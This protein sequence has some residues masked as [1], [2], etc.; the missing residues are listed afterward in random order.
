MRNLHAEAVRIYLVWPFTGTSPDM[1]AATGCLGDGATGPLGEV[2]YQTDARD[3]VEGGCVQQLASVAGPRRR[4]D[5][6]GGTLFWIGTTQ[7]GRGSRRA[8]E[9]RA[10]TL[11]TKK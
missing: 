7:A 1:G 4:R 3:P 2:V 6:H 10:R 9:G 11:A 8:Q 5:G